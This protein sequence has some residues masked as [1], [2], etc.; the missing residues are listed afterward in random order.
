MEI[1]RTG[2]IAERRG[3]RVLIEH[4]LDDGTF[5]RMAAVLAPLTPAEIARKP[6]FSGEKS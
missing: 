5:V 6:D 1:I 3:E 4:H 2:E